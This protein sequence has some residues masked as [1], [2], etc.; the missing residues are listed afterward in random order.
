MKFNGSA[1]ALRALVSVMVVCA[2]W[3]AVG[4]SQE[5]FSTLSSVS[6]TIKYQRGVSEEHVRSLMDL[7]QSERNAILR[8]VGGDSSQKIEVR[9]YA[10]VGSFQAGAGVKQPWRG[11]A[12]A[13][14][15]LHMQPLR[16]L[17]QRGILERSVAYELA[18]A[19]LEGVGRKGC[20]RWLREAYAVHHSGE[21]QK[22][23]APMGVRLSSF[24]DLDQDIQ[25]YPN[26][27]QRD[28]IHYVLGQTM[29]FLIDRFTEVK[30]LGVYRQFDGIKSVDRIFKTYFN[31]DYSAVERAWSKSV[32]SKAFAPR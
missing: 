25:T 1:L 16:A 18:L 10:S 5:Y 27:P 29:K 32:Q 7:L 24:S 30:A 3:P 6:F 22:L 13:K 26:P 28:D 11:A 2:L 17:I 31:E 8:E 21:M 20:P 23:S 15:I 4:R 14:E 12:Y 9:I 19:I